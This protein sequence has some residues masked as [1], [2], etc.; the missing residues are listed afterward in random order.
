[1]A[2]DVKAYKTD[3]HN[4]WCPG[5]V[6]P[7]TPIHTNPELKP[8]D[9]LQAGD[10]VLGLDGHYHRVTEVFHHRYQGPMHRLRAKC[11]GETVL[12]PEHPV[13]IARRLHPKLH[14]ERFD[15]IWERVDRI[16]KG[17]YLAYPIPTDAVDMEPLPLPEK[18]PMDRR[19][20]PLPEEVELSGDFLRLAGYYLAEGWIDTRPAKKGARVE[21]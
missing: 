11:F 20:L 15:L 6:L 12:T 1:M 14:N 5:C 21:A 2:H 7:G 13:L 16:R 19:S 9:Q 10:Q 18:L 3:V 4:N 8:I 17:D